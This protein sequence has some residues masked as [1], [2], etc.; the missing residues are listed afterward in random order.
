MKKNNLR[1]NL[2]DKFYLDQKIS[3]EP[4]ETFKFIADI[5]KNLDYDLKSWHD[6][7]CGTGE[8]L[9][10]LCNIFPVCNYLEVMF[11][12]NLLR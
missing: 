3:S 11:H 10:Y 4:K 5:A 6:I 9:N 8:L 7:G 12:Q 2:D 1:N